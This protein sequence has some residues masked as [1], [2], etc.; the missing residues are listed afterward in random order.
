MSPLISMIVPVHNAAPYL[1]RCIDS[2]LAQSFSD[3]EIVLIDDGSTDGSADICN[4]YL[5][6][7]SRV[8][9]IRQ[10]N[11]GVSTARNRGM[12]VAN[13]QYLSFIDADDWVEPDFLAVFVE[14]IDKRGGIVDCMIQGFIEHENQTKQAS[15]NYYPSAKEI[16]ADL[17]RLEENWLISYVWNKLFRKD[18]IDR[19]NISYDAQIP[20]GEDYLFC[21]AFMGKCTSLT[22]LPHIGY[23]YVFPSTS[24]KHFSFSAWNRRLD[25]FDKL[26][27]TLSYIPKYDV[28]RFRAREFKIGLYVLR[29]AYNE[30]ITYANR[31][32]YLRKLRSWG[33]NNHAIH[34]RKYE[35]DFRLLGVCVL[36]LPLRWCDFL[37]YSARSLRHIW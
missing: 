18:V 24:R 32:A 13:G 37:L 2:L 36:Y 23:H 10:S 11:K 14:E 15:Y 3:Y 27:P 26:L 9:V 17:Y 30:Q 12:E 7:D 31:M 29:I 4:E 21:M 34:L 5:S 19:W 22:V 28:E 8:K 16:G 1:R 6:K 33:R 20:I 25:S 35:K